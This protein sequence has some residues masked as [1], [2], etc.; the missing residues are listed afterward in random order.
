M[1]EITNEIKSKFPS[2][3]VDSI[4]VGKVEVKSESAELEKFKLEVI[5]KVKKEHSVEKLKDEP[6]FR[7]YRDFF[8]RIGID[9]TKIRPA[10][11]ALI[12]RILLGNPIPKINS[13]VDTYNLAS[14]ESKIALAAFDKAKL[15]GSLKMRLA[16]SGEEFTGIGMKEPIRLNGNEVVIEDG[17]K[18][19]AVYP[20]RD[21]D[22]TK[23][24]LETKDVLLLACGVPGIDENAL[25]NTGRVAV[26]Y[27]M[28][29][30]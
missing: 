16:K 18:L 14:I 23:V 3:K 9:P 11:E 4:D 6:V 7:A 25:E 21:A 20:Y 15:S 27:I 13:L 28:R 10:A 12:R 1:I 19:V 8:W 5:G 22:S 29:F 26:E 2:L 17:R 24:T 30:C